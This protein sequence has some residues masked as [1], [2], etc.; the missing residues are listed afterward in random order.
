MFCTHV[1]VWFTDCDAAA[2]AAAAVQVGRERLHEVAMGQG[3]SEVALQ[4]LREC[5]KTGGVL[6]V[7]DTECHTWRMLCAMYITHTM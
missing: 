4:L 5:A 3:Q 6:C 2:A 1:T 7:F